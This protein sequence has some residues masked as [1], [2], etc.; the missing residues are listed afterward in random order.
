MSYHDGYNPRMEGIAVVNPLIRIEQKLNK[1][2]KLLNS[3]ETIEDLSAT[4]LK[5]LI[6]EI[7]ND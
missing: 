3:E 5:E 4:D 7:L 1:I 2:Q 6:Q